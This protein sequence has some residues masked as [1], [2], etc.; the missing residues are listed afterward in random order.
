MSMKLTIS[1]AQMAV[2]VA[3]PEENLK[4]AESFVVEAKR[5][6]SLIICL[7]ELWTTG[8]NWAYND[9]AASRQDDT[10]RRVSEMAKR[11]SVW[12][13]GSMLALDANGKASN[14]SI[15]FDPAGKAA[16]TYRKTH[17]FSPLQEDR[18]IAPGDSLELFD[19]PWGKTGLAVC[20]DIRFPELF[21]TYALKGAKI[22]LSS[23]AFPAS[24]VAHW[25]ILVRARA[26]ENQLFMVGTNQVGSEDFGKAGVVGYCG[27]SVIIDPLGET[28]VEGSQEKEELL[29]A[30]ID[31]A[32][33]DEARRTIDYLKD[34]RTD[35]YDLC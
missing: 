12:I 8:L 10:I 5:R 18:H 9:S 6:G 15:L 34:R 31:T 2:A 20:Y 21:R 35:L 22:I 28:L 13:S 14:S 30:T 4:K 1:L 25:Q 16:A 3:K 32:R 26:I 23:M 17:L 7:P 29:T 19:A 24:R 11:H 27:H 33:V